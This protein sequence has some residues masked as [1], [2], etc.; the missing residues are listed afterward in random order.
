MAKLYFIGLIFKLFISQTKISQL[1]FAVDLSIPL[2]IVHIN[3]LILYVRHI[4]ST[5]IDSADYGSNYLLKYLY[6]LA[7]NL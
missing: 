6:R 4:E 3:E 7:I 5:T 1:D 2:V